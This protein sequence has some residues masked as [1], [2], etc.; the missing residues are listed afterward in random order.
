MENGLLY[1]WNNSCSV[2]GPVYYKLQ[3]LVHEK[4]PKLN[5]RKIDISEHP[6]L[7]SRYEIYSSP[8]ILL[9]LDGKEFMR[10]SGNI[11]MFE[12]D[13]KIGRLYQLKFED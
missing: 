8:M 12:L 1:F 10:T 13:R 7:R 5:L 11:S 2:C 3:S 4:Y 6:E 9:F